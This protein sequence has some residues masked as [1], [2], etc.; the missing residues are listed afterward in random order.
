[1]Q[2]TRIVSAL[3]LVGLSSL[4]C[5]NDGMTHE[6][7]LDE[8]RQGTIESP[9]D[10]GLDN[11]TVLHVDPNGRT[12]AVEWKGYNLRRGNAFN[13]PWHEIKLTTQDETHFVCNRSCGNNAL[14]VN[15]VR[16]EFDAGTE[17]VM[18]KFGEGVSIVAGIPYADALHIGEVF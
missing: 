7:D 6:P 8:D 5:I 9:Q 16:Y 15:G 12:V 4:A 10:Y 2:R 11:L 13:V 18:I 14:E 3:F 1:M 17:C